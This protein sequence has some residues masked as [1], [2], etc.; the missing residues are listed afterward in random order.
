MRMLAGFDAVVLVVRTVL[1]YLGILVALVC[2]FDWA[3]RSRRVNPFSRTAR[4]FRVRIDPLMQPIERVIVRT[5]GTPASAPL[6]MLV[7]FVI[8]GILLI[9]LLQFIGSILGQLLFGIQDPGQLPKLLLSWG[10]GALRVAILVRVL[11]SWL[12]VSPHSRW[13]RW[14]YVLTEWFIRPLR[15]IIPRI[16]MIDIT[17]IVAWFLLSIVQGLLSIP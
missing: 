11:S 10:F 16:G 17:P 2:A 8:A 7:A 12:P 3:V 6:W 4:F 13:I 1:L 14:S 5:G 15:Q 9:S